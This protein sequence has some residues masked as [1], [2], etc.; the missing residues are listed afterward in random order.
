MDGSIRQVMANIEANGQFIGE[1]VKQYIK[2]RKQ[3]ILTQN[4]VE[5]LA[6]V[7]G[8]CESVLTQLRAIERKKWVNN[9]QREQRQ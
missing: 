9:Q 2:L 5:C 8:E 4:E 6:A 7:R 1:L 3:A